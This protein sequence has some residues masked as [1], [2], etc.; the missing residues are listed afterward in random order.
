M[1]GNSV[2]VEPV[3]LEGWLGFFLLF[4]GNIAYLRCIVS[5]KDLKVKKCSFADLFCLLC[6]NT[7]LLGLSSEL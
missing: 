7:F 5:R 6:V 2:S 1:V 3:E 4:C